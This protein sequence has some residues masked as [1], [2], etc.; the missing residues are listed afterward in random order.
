MLVNMKDVLEIADERN[1]AIGS[2][3]VYS[4]E[5]IK[6]VL[7]CAQSRQMPAILAFGERYLEN[8]DLDTVVAI[9]KSASK[10]IDVPFALHLDH[11]NSLDNIYRAIK[12][13]FTSV[14]YDGS[15][16]SYEENVANTAKVVEV[17]HANQVSVEA[18]LGSLAS[19]DHSHEGTAA[20]EEV[21]T[22]PDQANDFVLKTGVD[23]LAV[24]IGTVHG[25]YKGEPNIRVDILKK[26]REKVAVPLVLHGGSG[27]PEDVVRECIQNGIRKINV[28]TEIS[29]YTVE[30]LKELQKGEKSYHLSV[31]S[32][33][34]IDYIKEVVAKYML[35]FS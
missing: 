14:M 28:N 5:T 24:S 7:E 2:F 33:K 13:G 6:G 18:E 29:V 16:L 11:C 32:L 35:I 19:G 27:T 17:A 15:A 21:Y 3:N 31:L 10:E 4:Y 23:A 12:A 22:N 30:K 34:Q 1:I 20:D 26:I 9:V 25:I 8:M